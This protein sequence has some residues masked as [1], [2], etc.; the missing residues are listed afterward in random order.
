MDTFEVILRMR[1][2]CESDAME[3]LNDYTGAETHVEINNIRQVN[4]N[5][6][7][8]VPLKPDYKMLNQQLSSL[9]KA[10]NK[11]KGEDFELL[12]GLENFISDILYYKPF[13]GA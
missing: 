11:M 6:P 13:K 12:Q 1:A 10:T 8:D 5:D 7:S 9:E 4:E 3:L 2:E